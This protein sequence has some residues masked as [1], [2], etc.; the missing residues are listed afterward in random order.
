MSD[1]TGELIDGR[2]ELLEQIATGGMATI[3]I[4]LDTRLDRKVAVKIMHS[5]LAADE[6]FVNRFIKEAKATAALSHPNIVSVQDQ[7][8]NQGGTPAVFLVMEYV[9][10]FTLREFLFEQGKLSP[11]EVVRHL[12][13]V[14]SALSAA[15]KIGIVH[16]DIKPENILISING[17]VKVADFGL[18]HGDLLGN[19]MTAE[20][21]VILG[22]VS[23]LSPE[24]VLRGVADSRSDVYSVGIVAFELLTGE[25]P[26][27]GDSPINIAYKHVNERVPAPSTLV[28]GIPES[29]DALVLR[30]TSVNPD[31]RPRDAE[32]F[33]EELR[34][35]QI[36]LDPKRTQMS[37]E[38]DLPPVPVR[39]KSRSPKRVSAKP[40][41]PPS[42]T[43]DTMKS[44]RPEST[45]Q[46]SKRKASS[47]VRRNRWIALILVIVLA[48]GFWYA[49]GALGSRVSIQTMAGMNAKEANTYLTS[50]GLHS[51]VEKVFS[52]E[53]VA[54]KIISTNPGGGGHV[55][56]G[57]TVSLV[58]SKG[59]ERYLIP[60]VKSLSTQ[61]AEALLKKNFLVLGTVTEAFSTVVTKGLIISASPT[62]GTS[63]RRNTTVDLLMSK[64]IEQI[65]LTSYQGKSSDQALN[66]LTAAGFDVT[67]TY[68]FSDTVPIGIVV[69]Q[70]P[71]GG[72]NLPKGTKVA[73]VISKGP[74]WVFIP[75][76]YSLTQEKATT[77]LEDLNLVVTIKKIG[78]RPNKV[79]IDVS[80]TVGSKVKRGSTVVVTVG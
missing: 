66:E 76:V 32:D 53:V 40:I 1:L 20:T 25:K 17:R 44:E 70:T 9:E 16:R 55:K 62:I 67:P 35:I 75:N 14:L 36:E 59:P 24:Q 71:D 41:H 28:S 23:Y 63:V 21:S 64:G 22:S 49:F 37:L 3:Y 54:G 2:Y 46:I 69:S 8:W 33:L 18:A 39:E 51:R 79:V 61:S 29:L 13:P 30:A 52:E 12:I 72:M 48:S 38:L 65:P 27:A 7:G 4:A 47:R 57:G 5:H 60:N 80:P 73:L 58:V 34:E 19:T 31:D 68:A 56:A 50:L 10:G 6:K 78:T 77:A 74:E 26:F 11:S 42:G 45:A 43:V 15:H